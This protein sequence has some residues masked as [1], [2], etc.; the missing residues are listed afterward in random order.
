MDLR[1]LKISVLAILS[2]MIFSSCN[3]TNPYPFT[4]L[5]DLTI[6]ITN[7]NDASLM[8]NSLVLFNIN[9]AFYGWYGD[10]VGNTIKFTD[11]QAGT[12]KL[13]TNDG[14]TIDNNIVVNKKEIIRN[15]VLDPKK[16]DYAFVTIQNNTNHTVDTILSSDSS[17]GTYI[18]CDGGFSTSPPSLNV[19]LENENSISII[20]FGTH[21]RN[22]RLK[23]NDLIYTKYDIKLQLNIEI[24]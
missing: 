10:L 5:A 19:N 9:N 18:D 17:F 3:T 4:G 23:S 11:V 16:I 2:I 8:N 12:Y 24:E 13:I 1:L 20:H 6:N 22:I 15:I 14:Q 7:T 21:N